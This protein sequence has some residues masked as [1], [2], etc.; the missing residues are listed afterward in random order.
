MP[1]RLTPRKVELDRRFLVLSGTEPHNPAPQAKRKLTRPELK[2][3]RHTQFGVNVPTGAVTELEH[4]RAAQEREVE[5]RNRRIA[6]QIKEVLQKREQAR[7]KR[8][9]H[10]SD[11]FLVREYHRLVRN[12]SLKKHPSL[13]RVKNLVDSYDW[14]EDRTTDFLHRK[15]R[16]AI[17][18][19]ILKA[20]RELHS[21]N[22][23]K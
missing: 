22:T 3:L 13:A 2:V 5:E 8:L 12:G 1:G 6:I 9:M 20:G 7:E 21:A 15:D 19:A 11:F 14:K 16:K 10:A 18:E 4:K 23:K 17:R